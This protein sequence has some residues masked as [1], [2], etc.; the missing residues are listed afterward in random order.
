MIGDLADNRK[1]VGR[2]VTRRA[3]TSPTASAER[4]Q[5]HRRRPAAAPDLPARAQADDGRARRHRRRLRSPR[6][7]TSTPR[8][9]SSRASSPTSPASP[10]RRRKNL[11]SL[12]DTAEH[13][14]ARD[15]GRPPT[16]AELTKSDRRSSP[17][18]ANNLDDRPDATS[19]TATA[20]VEKDPR[21]PGGQGYTG[22]EAVLQYMFDQTMAINIYDENGHIL[23]INLFVVGVQRLPE[24]RVAQAKKL[25]QD[26]GFL[27]RCLAGLGPN[28]PGITHARPDRTRAASTTHPDAPSPP[29]QARRSASPRRDKPTVPRAQNVPSQ[30]DRQARRLD[31]APARRRRRAAAAAQHAACRTCRAS[32]A[33][34]PAASRR[35]RSSRSPTPPALGATDP[36]ALLDYL[37]G[38]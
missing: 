10:S 18:L 37:L 17:E 13:G 6:S 32:R 7:P 33:A 28:Q 11:H 12:A 30:P 21:S 23:K 16:V 8:P 22:F 3:R 31:E 14:A 5:R 24:R 38:P 25:K 26:P 1:N 15:R 20:R 34:A 2:F 35:S 29:R 9:A 36:T 4:R 27:S 19:T